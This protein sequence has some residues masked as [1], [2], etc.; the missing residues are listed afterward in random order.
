MTVN[1]IVSMIIIMG[2]NWGIMGLII[3]KM[4]KSKYNGDE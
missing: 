2:I 3:W 4:T 1:G